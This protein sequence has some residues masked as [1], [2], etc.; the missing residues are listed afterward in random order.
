ME[1][2]A[3]FFGMEVF[4]DW[5]PGLSALK[6]KKGEYED[7]AKNLDLDFYYRFIGLLGIMQ[8]LVS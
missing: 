2:N 3:A 6:N 4:R 7:L 8:T 1:A 5:S